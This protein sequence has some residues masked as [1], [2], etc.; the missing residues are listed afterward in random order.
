M[1]R[2]HGEQNQANI[3]ISVASLIDVRQR[4]QASIWKDKTTDAKFM[5]PSKLSEVLAPIYKVFG[6]NRNTPTQLLT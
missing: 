5:V 1:H 6:I 2:N 4:V 3:H